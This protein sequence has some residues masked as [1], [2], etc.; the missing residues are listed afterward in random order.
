MLYA[1][2]YWSNCRGLVWRPPIPLEAGDRHQ[3][4]SLKGAAYNATTYFAN[5]ASRFGPTPGPNYEVMSCEVLE[6]QAT[7]EQ[8]RT[9]SITFRA[10][11]FLSWR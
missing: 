8:M 1:L 6:I 3:R 7:H 2:R 9:K 5:W 10:A 4:R 11:W